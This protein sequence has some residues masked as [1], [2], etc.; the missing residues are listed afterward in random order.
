MRIAALIRCYVNLAQIQLHIVLH[1][2]ENELEHS[3]VA[4]FV[5]KLH[6]SKIGTFPTKVLNI[7]SVK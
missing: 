4:V 6:F 5:E 7:C 3:S 1:K 2:M